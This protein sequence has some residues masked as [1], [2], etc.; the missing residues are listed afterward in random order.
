MTMGPSLNHLIVLEALLRTRS[1]TAAAREL[2]VT[3]SAV[4]KTLAALRRELADPLLLRRGDGMVATPRAERL[5]GP[6]A[7]SLRSLR[8]LVSD[9]PVDPGPAVVV[10]AMRDQFVVSLGAALLRAVASG[11]PRT[12]VRFVSYDRDRIGD[13][14]ARGAVDIAIA[15]DPPD[16]PGLRQTVLYR[17]RFVCM[18]PARKR[19]TLRSYLAEDHVVATAH[20]GYAGIDAALEKMGYRRRVVAYTTYFTAA[21]HL[22]DE[23]GALATLPSRVASSL[24]LRRL[25]A[26][27]LPVAL[28][29]FTCRMVWDARVDADVRN[30]WLR[31]VIRTSVPRIVAE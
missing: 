25:K 8:G 31:D 5:A 22:A 24:P 17:E 16:R 12:Q 4:S 18:A 15:V 26:Y 20:A 7:A 23:L 2:Q 10:V 14:L 6:L 13:E 9:S 3:Q 1:P 27:P 29:G 21:L 28:P 30:R 11:S 19:L